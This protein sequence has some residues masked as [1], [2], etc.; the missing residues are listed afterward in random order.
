[1]YQVKFSKDRQKF[2]AAHFT[3]F[4]DGTVERLHGHNYTVEVSVYSVH[5][6]R[7]LVF[8][9]HDAK[10]HIQ[11]LCDDW[12]EYVLLPA[13][14]PWLAVGIADGQVDV[15]LATP[16]VEKTYSF[17]QE[18]VIV[19]DC[20]NISSEHLARLF[21]NRLAELFR[22]AGFPAGAIDVTISESI[23]QAVTFSQ[24]VNEAYLEDDEAQVD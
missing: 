1:M 8:P 11:S 13:H 23:G 18:D 2:S 3:M 9:F 21:C 24:T 12:D 6:Q 5:L 20:D 15:H 19:L 22:N 4:E 10:R 7:G 17:P 16:A 14:H